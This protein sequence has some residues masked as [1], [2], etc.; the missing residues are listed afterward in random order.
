MQEGSLAITKREDDIRMLRLQVSASRELD[1]FL[2]GSL[3]D[4]ADS[5]RAGIQHRSIQRG[6]CQFTRWRTGDWW[7]M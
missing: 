3:F 4:L 7:S 5:N 1:V 2:I 6:K